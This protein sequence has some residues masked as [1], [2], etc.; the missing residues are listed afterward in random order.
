MIFSVL[1][2]GLKEF[3][4][5]FINDLEFNL[6]TGILHRHSGYESVRQKLRGLDDVSCVQIT[7][8]ESEDIAGQ[9]TG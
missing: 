5:L 8:S 3:F 6:C 9:S 4:L 2:I 1:T 7:G